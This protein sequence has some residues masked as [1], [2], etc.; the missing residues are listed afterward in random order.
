M[1]TVIREMA[2]AA[3]FT[4]EFIELYYDS[5][6]ATPDA[7]PPAAVTDLSA[8]ALPTG[9]IALTWTRP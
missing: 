4:K 9:E 1:L 8:N 3:D 5:Q 7:V 6:P 2:D